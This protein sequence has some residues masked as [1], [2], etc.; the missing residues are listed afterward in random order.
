MVID[1]KAAF[2]NGNLDQR[3]YME[4]P[5]G[6]ID[7]LHPDWVCELKGLLYGLKQSSRQWNQRLHAVLLELGLSVS[8]YDPS[9]YY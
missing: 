5:E 1:I 3:L 6:F 9:L 2:L 8:N 7:P 4:Q